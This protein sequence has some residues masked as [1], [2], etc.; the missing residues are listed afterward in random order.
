MKTI[1]NIKFSNQIGG[2]GGIKYLELE[3]QIIQASNSCSFF[4][5][6]ESKDKVSVKTLFYN[7]PYRC[8]FNQCGSDWT[9]DKGDF[10]KSF[11]PGEVFYISLDIENNQIFFGWIGKDEQWKVLKYNFN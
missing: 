11:T 10:T 7:H 8:F 5:I 9:N 6:C 1:N 3:I 4:G 2:I